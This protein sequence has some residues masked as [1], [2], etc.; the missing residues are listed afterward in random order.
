M[1]LLLWQWS[2]GVQFASLAMIAVFF[3]VL[4]RSL[5]LAE[6]RLWALAWTANLVALGMTF[7]YWNTR[8]SGAPFRVVA[9]GYLS[10]KIVFTVLLI[11]GAL[12]LR[13]SSLG[14]AT[15]RRVAA[16]VLVCTVLGFLIPT[17]E[18]LGVV[19]NL[20][21]TILFL[22]GGLLLLRTHRSMGMSWLAAAML[23]RS[24]LDFLAGVGFLPHRRADG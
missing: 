12:R 13:R 10:A 11:L 20:T 21:L 14:R 3:L 17:L 18:V 23:L 4:E 8:P 6:L 24:A 1:E 7:L 5:R 15:E 9:V 19:A 2:V 22:A 16:G